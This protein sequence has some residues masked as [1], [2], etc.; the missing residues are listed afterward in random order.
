[1][2]EPAEQ[3]AGFFCAA[4]PFVIRLQSPRCNEPAIRLPVGFKRP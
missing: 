1:M 3:S 2:K 4:A